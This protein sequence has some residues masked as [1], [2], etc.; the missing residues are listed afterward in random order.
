MVLYVALLASFSIWLA[1][2]SHDLHNARKL[3]W[4]SRVS[5]PISFIVTYRRDDVSTVRV[6]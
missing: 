5:A 4:R 1:L 3:T 6:T 2:T